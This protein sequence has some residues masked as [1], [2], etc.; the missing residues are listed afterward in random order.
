M[1]TV[2]E[3][4]AFIK[5]A[6]ARQ[7]DPEGREYFHHLLGVLARTEQIAKR[8]AIPLTEDI[9]HAALLHDVL[10]DTQCTAD[11]LRKRGYSGET[12][13]ILNLVGPKEK[14]DMPKG[15]TDE[16]VAWYRRKIEHI[17]ESGN[18]GAILVKSGDN[19]E[20]TDPE[21]AV[22]LNE[23]NAAWFTKKYAGIG[24]IL[25]DGIREHVQQRTIG[26]RR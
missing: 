9:K 18:I 23:E 2:E 21:R 19:K 5:E 17:V 22:Q 11:D 12:L 26:S 14:P 10:E 7:T 16:H 13:A 24:Q 15:R 8:W 25:E 20:N 4:I 3:T 6:H 1:P